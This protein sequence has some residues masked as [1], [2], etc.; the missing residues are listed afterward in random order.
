MTFTKTLSST[1]ALQTELRKSAR[2]LPVDNATLT[3][4]NTA[5]SIET[6]ALL[7]SDAGANPFV[8]LLVDCAARLTDG[9]TK[10]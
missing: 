8:S 5:L 1:T 9:G 6:A 2:L 10:E 4:D 3:T 7:P